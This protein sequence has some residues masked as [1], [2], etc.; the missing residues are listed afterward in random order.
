M[1]SRGYFD[2]QSITSWNSKTIFEVIIEL[3]KQDHNQSDER[4]F[5]KFKFWKDATDAAMYLAN[6]ATWKT[7]KSE[8]DEMT[9]EYFTAWLRL[10]ESSPKEKSSPLVEILEKFEDITSTVNVY[11]VANAAIEY[12]WRTEFITP[13]YVEIFIRG[14]GKDLNAILEIKSTGLQSTNRNK[15]IVLERKLSRCCVQLARFFREYP[16]TS[17]ECLLTAFS[18]NPCARLFACLFPNSKFNKEINTAK[19][20][21]DN[22]LFSELTDTGVVAFDVDPAADEDLQ[23]P[24]ELCDDLENV[25]HNPRYMGLFRWNSNAEIERLCY[26]FL[27]DGGIDAIENKKLEYVNI[28]Y[29]KYKDLPSQYDE[30]D[31]GIENGYR[32]GEWR[33]RKRFNSNLIKKKATVLKATNNVK[34]ALGIKIKSGSKVEKEKGLRKKVA[35]AIETVR[36]R[37]RPLKQKA[38]FKAAKTAYK[39]NSL[40][41]FKPV[42]LGLMCIQGQV[43]AEIINYD[44]IK[45]P[46]FP[47][48][49][50]TDYRLTYGESFLQHVRPYNS[51]S[52]EW[53]EGRNFQAEN[54]LLSSTL[55]TIHIPSIF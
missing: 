20:E 47:M 15:I 32:K 54:Q 10:E 46:W 52:K 51:D 24:S 6:V 8:E 3:E 30:E 50:K 34:D 14:M 40:A 33:T 12:F 44:L 35:A 16:K 29:E 22:Y 17:K 38:D 31:D 36:K 19:E 5:S 1:A 41:K 53:L 43:P 25:I 9:H 42:R 18:L 39:P 4:V 37:T 23:I 7:L 55:Q 2:A 28:D 13:K 48:Y 26:K 11:R 21:E 27:I 45:N 49:S